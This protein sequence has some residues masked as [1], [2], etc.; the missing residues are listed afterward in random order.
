MQQP[1]EPGYNAVGMAAPASAG[2]R[3]DIEAKLPL[4]HVPTLLDVSLIYPRATTY[5]ADVAAMQ[6]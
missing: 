5:L 4:P 6:R 1:R 2:S 3:A